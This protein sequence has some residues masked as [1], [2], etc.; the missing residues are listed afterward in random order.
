M[1]RNYSVNEDAILCEKA[2][3]MVDVVRSKVIHKN[4]PASLPP[5]AYW[6]QPLAYAMQTGPA[7]VRAAR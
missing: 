3:K 1:P 7:F 4:S 6:D 2:K 5:R